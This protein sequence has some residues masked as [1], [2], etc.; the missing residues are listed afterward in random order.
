MVVMMTIRCVDKRDAGKCSEEA[1]TRQTVTVTHTSLS[2]SCLLLSSFGWN[3][4]MCYYIND[5]TNLS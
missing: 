3:T 2:S 5:L 4:V 1:K